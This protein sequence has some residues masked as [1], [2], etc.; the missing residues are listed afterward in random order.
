VTKCGWFAR[1]PDRVRTPSS[2]G[3]ETP[4]MVDSVP[5]QPRNCLFISEGFCALELEVHVQHIDPWFTQQAEEATLCVLG[6]NV[7]DHRG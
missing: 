3:L 4:G 7:V 2:L 6:D 1:F 5:S